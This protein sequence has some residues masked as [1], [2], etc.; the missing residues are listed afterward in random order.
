MSDVTLQLPPEFISLCEGDDTSPEEVLRGFVADLCGI[1]NW[2][3][4]P[5]A[6]GYGSNGSDERMY[7]R[8]YYERCGYPYR[9]DYK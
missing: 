8:Q 7:A 2:A 1:T 6:D 4:S 5:R 3:S 9:K